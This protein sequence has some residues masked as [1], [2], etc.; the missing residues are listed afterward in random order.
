M[1]TRASTGEPTGLAFAGSTKSSN[2]LTLSPLQA[3]VRQELFADIFAF[4]TF[5]LFQ[6]EGCPPRNQL[7]CVI[8]QVGAT[9]HSAAP[10]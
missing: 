10:D 7:C 2:V 6:C 9:A 8:L 3:L 5:Q 1:V 4:V